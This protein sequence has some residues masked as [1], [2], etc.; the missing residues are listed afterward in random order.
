LKLRQKLACA[1]GAPPALA[2]TWPWS[3]SAPPARSRSLFWR[4]LCAR[5]RVASEAGM[6][7]GR[8]LAKVAGAPK[9]GAPAAT[10]SSERATVSVRAAGEPR[11]GAG[12]HALRVVV[13]V[14]VRRLAGLAGQVADVRGQGAE[15][16]RRPGGVQRR[17]GGRGD[18][19]QAGAHGAD[20]LQVGAEAR[21][22]GRPW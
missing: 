11:A 14:A 15:R 16:G 12:A 5:S 2:K 9:T 4:A 21:H 22:G 20:V 13:V 10:R 19:A 6:R 18:R 7:R 3:R 8:R 17:G 1:S